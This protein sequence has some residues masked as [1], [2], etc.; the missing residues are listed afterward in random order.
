MNPYIKVN[1]YI[2][3]VTVSNALWNMCEHK[4][5]NQGCPDVGV[6]VLCF[7]VAMA[8]RERVPGPALPALRTKDLPVLPGGI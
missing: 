8:L 5:E 1:M 2:D 4:Q 7:I 3:S 6:C